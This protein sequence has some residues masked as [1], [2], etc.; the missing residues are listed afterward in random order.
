MPRSQDC[1]PVIFISWQGRL[2]CKNTASNPP[3]STHRFSKYDMIYVEPILDVSSRIAKA[4]GKFNSAVALNYTTSKG[5]V[6][7][8]YLQRRT[9]A[10]EFGSVGVEAD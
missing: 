9:S 3:P 5:T 1:I 7:L 2:T 6:L 8:L 10:A 4:R